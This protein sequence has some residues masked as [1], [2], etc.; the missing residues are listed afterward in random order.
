[1]AKKLEGKTAVI[2]GGSRGIGKAIALRLARD[3][4]NIGILNLHNQLGD[5][6]A[7]EIRRFA[8][9]A[10]AIQCDITNYQQTQEAVATIHREFGS[11]D[12]LVN[13]A[14]ID[15]SQFFVDTDPS[16]WDQIINVNY[17]GFLIAT[18]VC[19]PYMIKQQ[20]GSIIS[21]GS[22][23]GRVGTAGE[24]IYCGTKGAIVAS[25]KALAREL[26]QFNIRV[27]CVSPGP[28]QTDLWTGLH[29]EE[30]GKKVTEA[31]TRLIPMK[32][33]ATPKDVADVVA[34]FVSED[35]RYITGQVLSVDGGLT[36]IG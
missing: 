13:N 15:K 8:G 19:L 26:A 5:K 28:V 14:G 31:I 2:T 29:E 33:I 22:D 7:E 27:N 23:A 3:G 6:T 10:L 32:R 30:K 16:L 21:L 9:K 11:I 20:G 4:A 17:K 36:M 35:A 18:H 25:S 1:M 34:F 12:I 24:V